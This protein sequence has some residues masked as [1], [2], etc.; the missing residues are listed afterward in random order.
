MLVDEKSQATS[1]GPSAPT[2]FTRFLSQPSDMFNG[3][4]YSTLPNPQI[5]RSSLHHMRT[6]IKIWG[7]QSPITWLPFEWLNFVSTK[8]L[9]WVV[10]YFFFCYNNNNNNLLT[11]SCTGSCA[12]RPLDVF[13]GCYWLIV[14]KNF[15]MFLVRPKKYLFNLLF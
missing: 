7:A 15:S 14:D 10:F 8:S 12:S 2:G 6:V 3:I 4:Y 9:I 11:S 1:I 5:S 13:F